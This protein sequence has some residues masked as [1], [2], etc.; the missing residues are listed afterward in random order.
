[1]GERA[2]RVLARVS[3]ADGDALAFAH[4]HILRV[5]TARWLKMEV[6]AGARFALAAGA[7]SVLG[8]ERETEVIERWNDVPDQAG[9]VASPWR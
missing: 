4:G 1:V 3:G 7:V 5:L 8:H 2:G 6:A 9:G